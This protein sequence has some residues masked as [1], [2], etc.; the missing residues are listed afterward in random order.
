MVNYRD[1]IVNDGR[2]CWAKLRRKNENAPVKDEIS[3]RVTRPAN[4]G[5][6]CDVL[7]WHGGTTA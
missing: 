5:Y 2:L 3:M 1:S 7:W 4:V 6:G